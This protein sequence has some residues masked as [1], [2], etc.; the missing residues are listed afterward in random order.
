MKEQNL[1]KS[2]QA[3]HSKQG[4]L[5]R[6]NT[7]TAYQGRRGLV[8]GMIMLSDPRPIAF[9]LCVGSSDLIG[10]TETIVTPDMVGEKIAIFTAVEVKNEK[11]KASKE[12]LK[13]LKAVRNA[14]GIARLTR[15]IDNEFKND[16]I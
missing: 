2:L 14:G 6:N 7:G 13:F 15:Y 3:R 9:G 11:G 10:W 12:Q 8:N 1:Y 4:I 16:E 5:F